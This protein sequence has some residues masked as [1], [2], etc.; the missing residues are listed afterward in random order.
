MLD[1]INAKI[2]EYLQHIV[3]KPDITR[4]E[5][6]LLVSYRD[7]EEARRMARM[8]MET[9]RSTIKSASAGTVNVPLSVYDEREEN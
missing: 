4:E 1:R 5:F 7:T 9:L 8:S 3:D 6:H 2:E